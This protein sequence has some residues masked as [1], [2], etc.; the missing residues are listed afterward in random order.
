MSLLQLGNARQPWPVKKCLSKPRVVVEALA[1]VYKARVRG[2][3]PKSPA[4]RGLT[5]VD[6]QVVPA[7]N[8]GPEP[9]PPKPKSLK[10]GHEHST[11]FSACLL[12]FFDGLLLPPW[13]LILPA[14][15]L[16]G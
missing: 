13:F 2:T 12:F 1:L 10:Q 11:I 5:A 4:L 7:S 8:M 15:P 6:G 9:S 16:P 14:G 3:R